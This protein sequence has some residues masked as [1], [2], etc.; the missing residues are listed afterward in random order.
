MELYYGVI[1]PG[2]I[3]END[4]I[5]GYILQQYICNILLQLQIGQIDE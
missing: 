3:M 4:W 2:Y 5:Q 1:S